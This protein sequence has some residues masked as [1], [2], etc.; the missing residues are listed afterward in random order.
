LAVNGPPQR[1][2][3]PTASVQTLADDATAWFAEFPARIGSWT[4]GVPLLV[5]RRCSSPMFDTANRIA[6]E[7]LI[8][9]VKTKRASAIRGLI[10]PSRWIDVTGSGEDKWCPHEGQEALAMIERIVSAGIKPD[11]YIVTPFVSVANSLR[12]L[13]RDSAV[14]AHVIPDLDRWTRA[15]IGTI[16]TVQGCEAEAVIF[17]L[18]APNEDQTGARAWAGKDPIASTSPLRGR[19]KRFMALE[20]RHCGNRLGCLRI[21]TR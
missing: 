11:L 2:G 3:A 21:S 16:H 10:G 7:N 20:T 4:V 15:N 18:G 12:R 14:L 8:V 13:F 1:F 5:H 19:R 17:V 9:Q 6:Y